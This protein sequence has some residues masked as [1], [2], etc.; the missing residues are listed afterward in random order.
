M[1]KKYHDIAMYLINH[2]TPKHITLPFDFEVTI[3]IEDIFVKISLIN[4]LFKGV[5][6]AAYDMGPG[7]RWRSRSKE[8]P[9]DPA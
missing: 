9:S 6:R 5:C 3:K 1:A 8:S 4:T 7:L 2:F